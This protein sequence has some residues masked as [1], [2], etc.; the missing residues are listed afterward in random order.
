MPSKKPP[1]ESAITR[2]ILKL[3]KHLASQGHPIYAFKFLGSAMSARQPDI[4]ACVN[5][6]SLVMEVKR[7]G[8]PHPLTTGQ[9]IRLDQWERSGAHSCVVETLD[10]A[11][12]IFEQLLQTDRQ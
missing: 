1:L 11:R 2:S 6:R 12:E 4:I 5:G 8:R 10:E 3:A 9:R 7:P